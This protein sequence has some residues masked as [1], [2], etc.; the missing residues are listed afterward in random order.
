MLVRRHDGTRKRVLLRTA[1]TQSDTGQPRILHVVDDL[2]ERPAS[3]D[4]KETQSTTRSYDDTDILHLSMRE[5]EVLR[6]LG[7]G[8]SVE[9]I[10][11]ELSISQITVRNHITHAMDK[12]G[13][14]SRLLAVIAAYRRG[15]I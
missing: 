5:I 10:A 4:A 14:N 9:Y 8:Q 7:N 12:L 11:Q 3:P 2:D 1:T 13:V 15:L 6:M